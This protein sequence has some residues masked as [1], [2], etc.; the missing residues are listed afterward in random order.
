MSQFDLLSR[1]RYRLWVANQ[2][3]RDTVG[4]NTGTVSKWQKQVAVALILVTVALAVRYFAGDDSQQELAGG[5]SQQLARTA[6]GAQQSMK[7][8]TT[9]G[10]GNSA[11]PPVVTA[12]NSNSMGRSGAGELVK[13]ATGKESSLAHAQKHADPTYVCPMHPDVQSKDGGATCPICGMDLVLVDTSGESDVVT[14]SPNVINMLGV[15]TD[16]VKKRNLY[17]K[18]DTVGYVTYDENRIRN[19]SLRTE[20]WLERMSVKSVGDR[21]EKV[22]AGRSLRIPPTPA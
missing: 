1:L 11:A 6:P 7:Q 19:V 4:G 9:M 17:R 8:G 16:M 10:A 2:G 20:G 5:V 13:T 12:A 15:R 21:V 14:I 3:I 22:E 18:I